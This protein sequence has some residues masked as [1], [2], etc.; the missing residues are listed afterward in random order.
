MAECYIDEVRKTSNGC[1]VA[2]RVPRSKTDFH[3]PSKNVAAIDFGTTN[4]S[5]AYLT[6][7]DIPERGPQRLLLSGNY[8]RVPNAVLFDPNGSLLSFGMD[9]RLEYS[10][11]EDDKRPDYIYF[12]HIKMNLQSDE[13]SLYLLCV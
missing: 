6:E 9:A 11:L 10:N 4:C 7:T 13:A 1:I 12:E 8:S 2:K 5:V 3:K